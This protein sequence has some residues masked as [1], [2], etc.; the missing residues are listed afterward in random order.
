MK[1][2]LASEN[3][4]PY[5]PLRTKVELLAIAPDKAGAMALADESPRFLVV[6]NGTSWIRVQDGL[7]LESI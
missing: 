1:G 6:W 3:P 5:A 4:F 2:V 7:A